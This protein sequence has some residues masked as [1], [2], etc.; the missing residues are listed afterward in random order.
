MQRVACE[1]DDSEESRRA[2]FGPPIGRVESR[3]LGIRADD[4]DA[5]PSGIPR[6][7]EMQRQRRSCDAAF[8]VEERS[9]HRALLLG[10][11]PRVGSAASV[12]RN[13]K[14][15]WLEKLRELIALGGRLLRCDFGPR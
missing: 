8:L 10:F 11:S 2:L 1:P 4:D 3:V 12:R 7:G 6:T 15:S 13:P 14:D 5:L 9:D